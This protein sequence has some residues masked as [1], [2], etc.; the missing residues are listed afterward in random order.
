[1]EMGELPVVDPKR[2]NRLDRGRGLFRLWTW[3]RILVWLL[4]F[5]TIY[6]IVICTAVSMWREFDVEAFDDVNSRWFPMRGKEVIEQGG[7]RL[8]VHL[9]TW[10][11]EHYLVL[12]QMGYLKNAPS[13]AF[14]PLWPLTI[15]WFSIFTNGSHLVAGIVLANAYS[16]AA[17][18]LF[19]QIVALRFNE[20]VAFRSLLLLIAFPGS[21]FYQFGYSESLFLLLVMILFFG[22]ERDRYGLAWVAA[23]LLPLARAVGIF[24]LLPLSWNWALRRDWPW[25]QRWK[26]FDAERERLRLDP[27][28]RS[29]NT[30]YKEHT[31]LAAPLFGLFLYFVLMR[32][33]TG[34]P[35]EGFHAQSYWG[36]H[37]ISNLWNVPKFAIELVMPTTVHDFRGS[38]LDRCLFLVLIYLLPV[39]W[40]LGKDLVLWA[41]M[42]GIL[43]AMSGMF[44][45]FTRFE[46]TVFPLFI[47]LAV[48]LARRKTQLPFICVLLVSS[49]L[50]S[51]LLWRFVN[52]RWAG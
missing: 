43:P 49:L 10:D 29:Y 7:P 33:W 26:C 6:F 42:L 3:P 28:V 41:L 39:V 4:L 25:L 32:A 21:L 19:Y 15:R 8:A 50:H 45:S 48:F 40:R 34:N 20:S 35:F 47:A 16:V 38:V 18:V 1:M 17:W 12:S 5:K 14:Y 22:L 52:F 30:S 27:V 24:S 36:V 44:V 31:V 2:P 11:A 46:S 9:A 37:S 51:I 13:C 23:F